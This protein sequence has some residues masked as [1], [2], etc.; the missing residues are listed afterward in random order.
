MSNTF[1]KIVGLVALCLTSCAVY[2]EK[3]S[4]SLSQAVFAATDS[5]TVGRFELAYDYS[6]QA[7]RLAYPP[8]T[9]IKISPLITENVSS[10]TSNNQNAK[11]DIISKNKSIKKTELLT[12]A[13]TIKSKSNETTSV[14]RIVIPEHL[15]NAKL[16]I[17]NSEEWTELLKQKEFATQLQIDKQNLQQ[18]ASDVDQEL[19]KQ[20]K[21]NSKMIEDLNR[22]E[23]Q[24]LAKNLLIIKLYIVIA[25]LI[26]TVGGGVYLRI[27]GIL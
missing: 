19:Q 7:E 27:K 17:E 18:V 24:I 1:L 26:L 20:S 9:R 23:K 3:R 10:I 8:K 12:N 6:K 16:L 11:A 14:L 21:M 4:E 13:I 2:T 5:I 25:L 15:K 22:M